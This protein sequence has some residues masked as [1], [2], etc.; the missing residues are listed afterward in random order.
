[1]K[2]AK[3]QS[4]MNTIIERK[5]TSIFASKYL[6]L[7]LWLAGDIIVTLCDGPSIINM[8]RVRIREE[9]YKQCKCDEC[10]RSRFT[11][12]G[13]QCVADNGKL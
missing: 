9:V 3:F 2:L 1:M 10:R 13:R 5:L 8:C 7:K 6:A 12:A 11:L 4:K